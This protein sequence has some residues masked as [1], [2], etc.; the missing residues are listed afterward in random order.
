V[1][2]SYFRRWF[3]NFTVTDNT[4]V[5]PSDFSQFSIVAPTDPRLPGGGGYTVAGLYNVSPAK[6][7]QTANYITLANN[8]GAMVQRYQGVDV[9]ASVRAKGGLTLQG[10]LSM[11]STLTDAC[12]V[13]AKLPEITLASG[14][15]D[16]FAVNPT[17]PYCRNATPYLVQA[18]GLGTYRI[19]KV[20]VQ[21]SAGIQS[22][23]GPVV[24][25]NF[26]A[27]N[28]ITQ[29]SLGRPLSGNAANVSVNLIEPNQVYGD[30]LN[31]VDMRISKIFRFG[32]NARLNAGFDLFNMFNSSAVVAQ[33]NSYS[34][35]T[36]TWQ[37]PQ[38]V[39]SARLVKVSAQFD[40]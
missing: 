31:Q 22:T 11:G 18:K 17:S 32:S 29:P 2:V 21:V 40:F 13:Q 5:A 6:F 39:V 28:A 15:G 7:G 27:T 30:R 19:P 10:G 37:Q 24:A 3:G 12:E 1:D 8:Y 26:N 34:P 38:T 25:A 35:T 20:D 33:N 36:T 4:L 14:F 9:N 16:P 23:P